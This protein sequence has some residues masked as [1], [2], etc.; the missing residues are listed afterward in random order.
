MEERSI[1]DRIKEAFLNQDLEALG[2]LLAEDVRWGDEDNPRK[3]TSRADVLGVFSRGIREGAAAEVVEVST[4][5]R[6]VLCRVK[7]RWPDDAVGPDGTKRPNEVELF[8]TYRVA[9]GK[10]VEIKRFDD[11]R[12][13][14]EDV[15]I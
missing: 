12:S 3:C 2:A 8:Q 13:A 6:G 4:G 5:K 15:G 7:F 11:R 1:A 14:T 10:I 9:N